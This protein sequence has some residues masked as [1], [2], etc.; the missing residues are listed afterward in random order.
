MATTAVQA[1]IVRVVVKNV[2][3]GILPWHRSGRV[4]IERKSFVG[5]RVWEVVRHVQSMRDWCI[6]GHYMLNGKTVYAGE[7]VVSKTL[8]AGDVLELEDP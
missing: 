4:I 2:P 1:G 6:A 8:E 3:K 7:M 5:L